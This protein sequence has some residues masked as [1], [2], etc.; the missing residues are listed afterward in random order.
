VKTTICLL[1]LVLIPAI[2]AAGPAGDGEEYI[3]HQCGETILESYFETDG[4]Y[5]HTDCFVCSHCSKPIQGIYTNYGGNHY[6]TQ[7]FE[8]H[9]A[10]RC[11]ICYGVITGE[12]L[13]DFWG[14]TCH[15]SHRDETHECEYCGRFIAPR[16]TGGGVRYS[17]GRYICNICRDSAVTTRD[18]ALLILSEVA[19]HMVEFGMVINLGEIDLHVVGLKEMQEKSGKGSYRLTG[20]TDFEET[21]SL[22]G[23]LSTRRIDVYLL[24]GM[25]R[26]DAVSTV[27]HELAHVWQFVAGQLKNDQAFA[28]GSCNYVSYLVLQNYGG[29]ATDYVVANLADDENKIYG[30]GFRRVKRYAEAEGIKTWL[31]RLGSKKDLPRG[32]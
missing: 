15:P 26:V 32:Y 22:F 16:I 6:H 14:N 30:E 9:V 11:A 5:Y 8:S 29:M 4:H 7:C 19:R 23:V 13:I 21:K 17:D 12:Y 24:Y 18:E 25:P 28:E 1:I 27:A 20:F 3:C 10:K 2:L 31:D